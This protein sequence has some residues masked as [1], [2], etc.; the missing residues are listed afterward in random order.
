[1]G[2]RPV[3]VAAVGDLH[4]QPGAQDLLRERFKRVADEADVLLIA[5][6]LTNHGTPEEASAVAEV[7]GDLD[8]PCFAVLGNHDH[9]VARADEVVR[10]LR[11]GGV[12][13][14]DRE[15]AICRIADADVGIVGTKGFVGGFTGAHLP[16]FG[17]PLLRQLHRE[18][19]DEVRAIEDGLREVAF[20]P[21]RILLL[22][23]APCVETI[24]GEP[25]GIWTMLGSDRLGGPVREH[26]P[27]LVVHGHA[28]AG[29]F[30]G[31]IGRTPVRNV[32]APLLDEPYHVFS[33]PVSASAPGLH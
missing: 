27:T 17:E 20:C 29:T 1:M 25:E 8:L 33:L 21:V 28:H 4:G 22:H 11:D 7:L 14:L 24:F 32:S 23:Y 15:H 19:T 9:H 13:V 31:S 10:A 5:G 16:D 18:T 6:D 2:E 26:E 12:G 3:R 30:A